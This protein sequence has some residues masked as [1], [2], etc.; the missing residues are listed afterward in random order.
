MDLQQ[1][2]KPAQ[3]F[4]VDVYTDVGSPKLL[5]PTSSVSSGDEAGT[6]TRQQQQR[7][8][9]QTKGQ[10]SRLSSSS[11]S[12]RLSTDTDTCK[13]SRVSSS[14]Q[15][16]ESAAVYTPIP[17]GQR[18]FC[19]AGIS[20]E[21]GQSLLGEAFALATMGLYM[22]W[23]HI[24]MMLMVAAIFSK[25]ALWICIGE[26]GVAVWVVLGHLGLGAAPAVR[27]LIAS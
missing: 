12:S 8:Q 6:D 14:T 27:T 19:D 18:I 25:T 20:L 9:G 24:L 7:D 21:R 5:S 16:A 10:A 26:A 11:S 1:R 3:P 2:M 13:A 23:I 17:V 22:S 4:L 15:D